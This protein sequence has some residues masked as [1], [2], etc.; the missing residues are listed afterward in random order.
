M[1]KFAHVSRKHEGTYRC[2]ATDSTGRQTYNFVTVKVMR[3]G[4]SQ[5]NKGMCVIVCMGAEG[6]EDEEF[7]DQVKAYPA[8][9]LDSEDCKNN[10]M[11]QVV[12][13]HHHNLLQGWIRHKHK[14]VMILTQLRKV[15]VVLRP[16]CVY[17]GNYPV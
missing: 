13:K 8:I 11:K 15:C 17:R 16:H 14:L 10:N 12:Q 1:L 9:P 5:C 7:E 3:K 6:L 4:N 2:V